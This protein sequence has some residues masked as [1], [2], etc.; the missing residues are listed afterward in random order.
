VSLRSMTLLGVTTPGT[1]VPP[2][3]QVRL[4]TKAL[5]RGLLRPDHEL[6]AYPR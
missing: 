3:K 4:D 1:W 2:A 5:A 6:T